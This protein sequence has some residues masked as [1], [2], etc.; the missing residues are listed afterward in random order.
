MS[1]SFTIRKDVHSIVSF[2]IIFTDT[3][4]LLLFEKSYCGNNAGEIF[5]DTLDKIEEKLLLTICK[6][7]SPLDINTLSPEE[8]QRF[9]S[10]KNC[11][12]CHVKIEDKDR[13]KCK[14][15]DHDHYSN[16]YRSASC[17]MCNLL[18]RS[19]SHIPIY[20]HNFGSYDSNYYSMS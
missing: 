17:T 5:F 7:K 13:L 18:N 3:N 20:F 8:L 4:G 15:L 1:K 14:N 2:S 10:A 19:Q 11:E 6:N 16:K 12:I 9:N